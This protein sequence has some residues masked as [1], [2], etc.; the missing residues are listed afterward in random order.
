MGVS[1][2]DVGG[3]Y[4]MSCR[5]VLVLVRVLLLV[6]VLVLLLVLLLVLVLVLVLV[7]VLVL[8]LVRRG[9]VVVRWCGGVMV[10][11]AWCAAYG[12]WCV[13]RRVW[14]GGVLLFPI[15]VSESPL[16]GHQNI[17]PSEKHRRHETAPTT[18]TLTRSTPRLQ[19]LQDSQRPQSRNQN[20][21]VS[22]GKSTGTT[23]SNSIIFWMG[24]FRKL[25]PDLGGS[26]R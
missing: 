19:K 22:S 13:V 4:P 8:V 25:G 3:S 24:G 20:A 6:L 1:G 18:N 15:C 7:Q 2:S 26:P 9:G 17:R 12:V 21:S 14:E 5:L 23:E 11:G 10:R 16:C